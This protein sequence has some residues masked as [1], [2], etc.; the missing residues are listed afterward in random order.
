MTKADVRI[1]V[2][3]DEA[4]MR[5]MVRRMLHQLGYAS[6]DEDDGT[7][8]LSRLKAYPYD[9]I[10]CDW[11]MTPNTGLDV[12]QFVRSDPVLKALP[13]ILLTAETAADAVTAAVS[14]G[15]SDYIAK[16][17][18]AQTLASKVERVLALHP[19]AGSVRV[20]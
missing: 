18:S 9:L 15:A 14:T 20:G 13:F 17:F 4:A 7:T 10:I 19:P 6:V 3:D 8:V 16:P 5:R 11:R 1:L 12:L 2:V